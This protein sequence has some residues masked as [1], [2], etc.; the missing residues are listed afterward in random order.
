M[1]LFLMGSF[2]PEVSRAIG[3]LL[4]E[5]CVAFDIGAN[6]GAH[7][8]QMA[9]LVGD[10]G[11][12]VAFEPTAYAFNKLKENVGLNQELTRRVIVKQMFLDDSI[13]A[14]PSQVY[15]SWP[16][17]FSQEGS[18]PIHWGVAKELKGA[19]STTLDSFIESS[20]LKRLDF[21]K[22]DV[23][24]YETQ[25]LNG[26]RR[27]L[28]RFKP[29]ILLELCEYVHKECG[30]S[31]EQFLAVVGDCGYELWTLDRTNKLPCDSDL[32]KNFIPNGGGINALAIPKR[33]EL[34]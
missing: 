6:I 34:G 14:L 5:G 2:E 9:Q 31:F 8:L 12:V 33:I 23:D 25:V 11:K 24:G 27:T 13:K 29:T 17:G 15:S 16:V 28:E 32:I 10:A 19:A 4:T 21:I 18:H 1:S 22:L 3:N 30:S 20:G 7:S 26:A